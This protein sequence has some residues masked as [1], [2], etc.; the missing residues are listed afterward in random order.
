MVVLSRDV[1]G[2]TRTSRKTSDRIVASRYLGRDLNRTPPEYIATT[3]YRKLN[4]DVCVAVIQ[5][6]DSS[7]S[8]LLFPASV[9]LRKGRTKTLFCR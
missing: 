9:D 1:P 5:G 3:D 7:G 8:W 2:G 6:A 4:A